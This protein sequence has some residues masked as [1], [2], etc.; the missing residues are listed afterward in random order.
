M[1]RAIALAIIILAA[2]CSPSPAY[3]VATD[4]ERV[5]IVSA[6]TDYY[7]AR[8]GLSTDLSID[9][10][11][12]R[13][14]ELERKLDVNTGINLEG[15]WARHWHADGESNYRVELEHY[16]PIH[17]SVR[18]N[19]AIARVHGLEYLSLHVAGQTVGEF[20][21]VFALEQRDGRWQILQTDEQMLGEPKPTDPPIR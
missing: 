14:P 4:A 9:E 3:R 12:L 5:K 2:G 17:A 13:Y 19:S 6:V 1:T 11:W 20:N 8:S 18:G 21:T 7:A 16:E 10:F 15:F